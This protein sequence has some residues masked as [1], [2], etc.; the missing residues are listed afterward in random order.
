[1]R[2]TF[3]VDGDDGNQ[4]T[5][6]RELPLYPGEIVTHADRD[7]EITDGPQFTADIESASVRKL[8]GQSGV[9]HWHGRV[10]SCWCTLM[11]RS[12]LGLP[13][14]RSQV[15]V[16]CTALTR[17]CYLGWLSIRRGARPD[18]VP[19]HW[20]TLVRRRSNRRFG[21]PRPQIC[22]GRTRSRAVRR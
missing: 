21:G 8:R 9:R 19:L 6:E 20:R 16:G 1:M 3:Q 5:D 18:P 14:I 15:L 4:W 13:R 10:T 12:Y 2:C 22:A 11:C 17:W 7:Y